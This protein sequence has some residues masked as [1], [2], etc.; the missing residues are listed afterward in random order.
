ME[1]RKNS[2]VSFDGYQR[3]VVVDP[4]NCAVSATYDYIIIDLPPLT[5]VSDA[6]I[7]SKLIDGYLLVVRHNWSEISKIDEALAAA[8]EITAALLK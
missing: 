7:L 1:F 2:A 5:V 3:R 4:A 6:A 8:K